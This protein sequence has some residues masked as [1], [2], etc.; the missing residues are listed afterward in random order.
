MR[1]RRLLVVPALIAAGALALQSSSA[2]P[3]L[4]SY[5]ANG[6]VLNILPPGSNGNVDAQDLATLGLST[7]GTTANGT[8]PAHFGDQLEMYDAL[9]T[10]DPHSLTAANLT[11]YYKSAQLGISAADT[12]STETPKAGVVIKRDKFGVPHI[13][14]TTDDDVA[15][16]SGY[17]N[18]EDRMFLTDAL[19][20][21][22]DATSAEFLGPSDANVASDAAQLRVA[23]YTPQEAQDQINKI[24]TRYG[25]EGQA[26]VDRLDSM[27]A[28]MNQA[29]SD[30][31]PG[32]ARTPISGNVGIG[33]GQKCPVEYAALNKSPE[34]YTRADIVAIA[35]LVGGIF[36]KG[37]GGEVDNAT[38]LQN[39][40]AKFGAAQGRK[41]FDDFREK[42]DAEAPTTSPYRAPWGGGGVNPD[43]PGVALPDLHPAA[44]A[45]GTGAISS[46]GTGTGIDP[47]NLGLDAIGRL[48]GPFGPIDLG[49]SH[50]G[51][52]NAMLVGAKH[53]ADGHP[54]VVFGPQTG[55]YTPQLLAEQDLEGPHIMAR[56]VSFAG[57]NLVVE[58]GHGVDYAWSATSASNDNV[59]TI[60]ER[61]C[62]AD[63]SAPTVNSLA[64]LV[65]S[66]CTPMDVY[67]HSES[68]FTNVSAQNAPRNVS[69]MVLRTRHGIVQLRT[70]VGGKPVAI[71]MQRSTYGHEIDSAIGFARL[72]DPSYTTS[73]QQFQK[74]VSAIDYTFNWFY[75]D[76]K[77][78]AYYCSGLLPVRA[79]GLDAD[80]PH[81]GDPKYDDTGWVSFAAHPRAI[82]PEQGFLVSWNNKPAPGWSAAD[83]DWGYGE[84]FRSEAL[85]DR[86]QQGFRAGVKFTPA[87]LV[88]AMA[89]AMTVDIRGAYV[90][91][92]V[93]KVLEAKTPG[94]RAIRMQDVQAV[95]LLSAW[96][97]AGAHRVDR[98]RTGSYTDQAAIA[99]MDAWWDPVGDS[100]PNDTSSLPKEVL[101]GTLGGLVDQL[102]QG[103]DD[104]P[105]I[106]RGSAFDDVAWYGYVTKDLRRVLGQSEQDPYSR[107]YCGTL[108][109]CQTRL[110]ASLDA[111][112]TALLAQEKASSVSALTYDKTRDDIKSVTAGVVGVRP[113]DWQNRPTFQQVVHFTA[114]R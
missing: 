90:L 9:N 53:T 36:G 81:W 44:T 89:D 40:E 92:L 95:Q 97:A 5:S 43:Q 42:N 6:A 35:S 41:I 58:L 31:C 99:I 33:L 113:I 104:H 105:R 47:S 16:G 80:L 20:H 23:S 79:K 14:G 10:I 50:H 57:T 13:F 62:N 21:T 70:T 68:A 112:V 18:I 100:V 11:T 30:L 74:A 96:V 29:Q 56:G 64:Y 52:S 86:I 12:V 34:P 24:V 111:A 84:V 60:V 69:F 28:G 106:G 19:R 66:K 71:V 101:R 4:L 83:N 48:S 59:D 1:P 110:W 108:S 7:R 61:L 94:P 103:Q 77:H 114:H 98:A 25:A 102:P 2:S 22:G 15:W 87:E 85:S 63:G 32:S 72:A 82:D 91:P 27:I 73:P 26:L 75:T 49:L 88:G 38:W 107:V 78:I 8:M 17:A 76:S 67:T 37:G 65:G 45:P 55:Y 93:L 39:L 3:S 46:D 109:S 54:V 51:M